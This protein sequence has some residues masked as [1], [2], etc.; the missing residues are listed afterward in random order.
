MKKTIL[1]ILSLVSFCWAFA[2][3][4]SAG[5]PLKFSQQTGIQRRSTANFFVDINADTT[6]ISLETSRRT[7]VSGVTAE[8]AVNVNDGQTF[9]DNGL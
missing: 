5:M 9:F 8:V 1:L 4:E 7:F 6:K 3:Y 2:Q